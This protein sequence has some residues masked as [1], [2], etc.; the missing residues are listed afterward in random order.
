MQVLRGFESLTLR[1]LG[2]NLKKETENEEA[3]AA[4]QIMR[5]FSY[6]DHDLPQITRTCKVNGTA[7]DLTSIGESRSYSWEAMK[8][9]PKNSATDVEREAIG[10]LTYDVGVALYSEYTSSGTGADPQA[11]GELYQ[12]T[13]DF[14]SGV[15]YWK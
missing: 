1:H 2:R 13:Y 8:L 11:L 3:T 5:Y 7:V 12:D 10:R 14:A 4:S 15:T 6:P 9:I